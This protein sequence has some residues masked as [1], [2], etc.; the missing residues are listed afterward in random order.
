MNYD[1]AY[2]VNY[3]KKYMTINEGDILLTGSSDR[4]IYV[5]ANDAIEARI[6]CGGETMARVAAHMVPRAESKVMKER[7]SS[8]GDAKS[9]SS[10]T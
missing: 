7:S 10:G 8:S 1:I 6:R 4:T 5:N 2:L 9:L 3:I